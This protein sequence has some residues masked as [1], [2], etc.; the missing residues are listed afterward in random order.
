M[1]FACDSKPRNV[2]LWFGCPRSSTGAEIGI[3]IEVYEKKKSYNVT[4]MLLVATQNWSPTSSC[5][6]LSILDA[7]KMHAWFLLHPGPTCPWE[8][9]PDA[10][11]I[12]RSSSL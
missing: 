5:W 3:K 7:S 1:L 10:S 6:V 8:G 2:W 4:E 9:Q 11:V 12:G